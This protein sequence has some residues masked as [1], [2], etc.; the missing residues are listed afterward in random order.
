MSRHKRAALPDVVAALKRHGWA[1]TGRGVFA[2]SEP[3]VLPT[4]DHVPDAW[5]G[6]AMYTD[7][8]I[9]S[10]VPRTERA[11]SYWT[12]DGPPWVGAQECKVSAADAIEF[13]TETTRLV[14]EAKEER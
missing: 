12:S 6:A 4:P 3:L 1:Q 8:R 14:A 5:W 13:I 11:A 9:L 7:H 2:P 10:I